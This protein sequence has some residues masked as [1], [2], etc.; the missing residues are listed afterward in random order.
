[1]RLTPHQKKQLRIVLILLIGIPLTSFAVYKGVQYVSDASADPTPRD[2]LLSNVTMSAASISWVT[3]KKVETYVVPIVNGTEQNPVGDRRGTGE[4]FTHY[5]EI[6]GLEPS[7]KYSFIILSDGE[8]YK[9]GTDSVYEFTTA[10][11]LGE[12]PTPNAVTGTVSGGG[13][14]DS[15][16]YIIL[17]DKSAYPVSAAVPPNGNWIIDLSSMKSIEDYE[18]VRI[19][20]QQEIVLIVKAGEENGFILEDSYSSI[21]N[22]DGTLNIAIALEL[23]EIQGALSYFPPQ[24]ILGTNYQEPEPEE[25]DPEP[26]DPEPEP[27][28]PN[29]IVTQDSRIKH[30]IPWS[31]IPVGIGGTPDLQYGEETIQVT[32]L[33]DTS[34][35]IVWRS[36]QQ[37]EGYVMYGT[38]RNDLSNE[39]RDTRDNYSS[40]NPYISHFVES[41]T[42]EPE[43]TYYFEIYSG[44]NKYD[45]DGEKFYLTTFATLAS[46][47]PLDIRDGT[48]INSQSL[49]DWIVVFSVID[50]DELGSSGSSTLISTLPDENG[51]WYVTVGDVRNGNGTTYFSYSD[52]DILQAFVLG[53]ESKKFDFSLGQNE[54]EIDLSTISD[55]ISS[56]RVD[57]LADYG[58]LKIE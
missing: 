34:F 5:T 58:I 21:F 22:S 33:T 38:D 26:E 16:V 51:E 1:M 11:V 13:A 44:T 18:T 48:L 8:E 6:T 9:E 24:S 27:E 23:A 7:T 54:L 57:L 30:D 31:S 46:P 19:S 2:V 37:E 52:S 55:G 49:S 20:D 56:G 42:V 29:P 36:A 45:D 39:I 15:L 17:K 35:T 3:E 53:A 25:P 28:D 4:R 32:N 14:D 10:P 43:T 47:P 41:D 12:T 50:N 40:M